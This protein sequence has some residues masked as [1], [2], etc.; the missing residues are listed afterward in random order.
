MLYDR[1]G[2]T[3][4]INGFLGEVHPDGYNAPVRLVEISYTDPSGDPINTTYRFAE[5]LK[6]DGGINEIDEA[7][8]KAHRRT[9][10]HQV[11]IKKATRIA[12]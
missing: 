11:A 4:V 12:M 7:V 1:W 9:G 5:F 2:N 6:A 10:I 8:N 3:L